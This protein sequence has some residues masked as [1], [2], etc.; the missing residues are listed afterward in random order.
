MNHLNSGFSRFD[1]VNSV[2]KYHGQ[3]ALQVILYCA[4]SAAIALVKLTTHPFDA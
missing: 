4:N 2:S 1:I 3:I